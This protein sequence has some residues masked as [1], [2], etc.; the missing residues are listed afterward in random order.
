MSAQH[1]ADIGAV[2]TYLKKQADV[3][4][5]VVGTSMGTFSAAEGAIA[6]KNVDGLVLSSTIT[7]SK[8]K[9]KI[10]KS[11]SNGVASMPLGKVSVPTLILSHKNDAC[12]ATPASDAPKLTKALGKAGRVETVV[13]EGGRKPESEPCEAKSEHGF[14]GIED[15]AVAAITTF[16]KGG[17]GGK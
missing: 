4:V 7:R 15:Q 10:A 6:G 3:P 17:R 5:W 9:W 16:V 8:P 1:G 11:H 14:W 12:E 13:L 2:A